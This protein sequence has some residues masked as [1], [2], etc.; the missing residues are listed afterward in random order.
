MLL[1]SAAVGEHAGGEGHVATTVLGH[2]PPVAPFGAT[3][4]RDHRTG[5]NLSGTGELQYLW[6]GSF[7]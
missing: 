3:D 5:D 4:G 2:N 6:L 7:L 1:D